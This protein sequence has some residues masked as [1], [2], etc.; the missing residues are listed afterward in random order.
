MTLLISGYLAEFKIA[1]LIAQ[2]SLPLA[3]ADH[4]S[5]VFADISDSKVTKSLSLAKTKQKTR[6]LNGVAAPSFRYE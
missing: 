6:M 1:H 3:A 5:P 2:H 4:L